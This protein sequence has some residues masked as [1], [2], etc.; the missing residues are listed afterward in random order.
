LRT[1]FIAAFIA[2]YFVWFTAGGITSGFA[3]D[4]MHNMHKYWDAGP[5]AV[6]KANL[7]FWTSFTGQPAEHGIRSSTR[8]FT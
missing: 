2:L 6:A 3:P 8:S 7:F 1:A 5:G 4:D